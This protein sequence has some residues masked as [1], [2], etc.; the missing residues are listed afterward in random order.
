MKTAYNVG[1]GIYK[2]YKRGN[3]LYKGA[4][5]LRDSYKQASPSAKRR[6]T[7]HSWRKKTIMARKGMSLST[8]LLKYKPVNLK[9]Y[10]DI[11]N[12]ATK[13][14]NGT[15]TALGEMGRQSAKSLGIWNT[16]SW[17]NGVFEDASQLNPAATGVT[18]GQKLYMERFTNAFLFN[19]AGPVDIEMIIYDVVSKTTQP[20]IRNPV[21]DW[22][23]GVANQ[24]KLATTGASITVP[25]AR[26][27]ESK[28]FNM[29][30][31]IVNRDTIYICP[32]AS[33]KHVFTHKITRPF[34]M[35]YVK[36]YATIRGIT[37]SSFIVLKGT[38]IDSVA[39]YQAGEVTIAPSKI[40]GTWTAMWSSR[41]MVQNQRITKA[42]NTFAWNLPDLYQQDEESGLV[43]PVR[44]AGA[45]QNFA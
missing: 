33:H 22:I 45:F 2:A 3:T 39:D 38:P 20:N 44:I 41:L 34:D 26:P 15:F 29:N 21:D 43:E 5:R 24:S 31:R 36:Q 42:E 23:N 17:I 16:N 40:I 10:R 14:T 6:K 35:E 32:G 8:G 37:N 28:L 13:S 7:S 1:R 12:L 30:W 19:N 4:K 11:T 27:T 9:L 25:F 18:A